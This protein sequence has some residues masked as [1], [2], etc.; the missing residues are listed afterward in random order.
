MITQHGFVNANEETHARQVANEPDRLHVEPCCKV[1][2]NNEML[3]VERKRDLFE[4][5]FQR[6]LSFSVRQQEV[7]RA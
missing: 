2:C 6:T 1:D 7:D 3:E 4:Q 5:A